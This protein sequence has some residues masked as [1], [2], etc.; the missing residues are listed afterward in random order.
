MSSADVRRGQK[1]T[2]GKRRLEAGAGVGAPASSSWLP[3]NLAGALRLDTDAVS[4]F[5][6]QSRS[7][8]DL[9]TT[10]FSPYGGSARA[11][12]ARHEIARRASRSSKSS[13]S[14]SQAQQSRLDDDHDLSDLPV[15]AN[16]IAAVC[17]ANAADADADAD[18][19][20]KPEV[21]ALTLYRGGAEGE[22]GSDDSDD[23]GDDGASVASSCSSAS[24]LDIPLNSARRLELT[25][26]TGLNA[27]LEACREF[28]T[29][30][31]SALIDKLDREHATL[32]HHLL[33]DAGVQALCRC[34]ARN[35][36]IRALD[37][38]NCNV[39]QRGAQALS[40]LLRCNATL[41]SLSL[42][43]NGM[44]QEAGAK[45]VECLA[46]GGGEKDSGEEK[47]HGH[48]DRDDD[49]QEFCD[50]SDEDE[51]SDEEAMFA[52]AQGLQRLDL[53]N[54]KLGDRWASGF[55]R[56]APSCLT[57]LAL[58]KNNI[59]NAG[60]RALASWLVSAGPLLRELD[61]GWN[62]IKSHGAKALFAALAVPESR[63]IVMDLSWNG[64]ADE[65]ALAQSLGVAVAEAPA[66]ELLN[67]GHNR[68]GRNCASSIATAL[69][70]GASL[71]SLQLGYN[72]GIGLKGALD[73]LASARQAHTLRVLGLQSVDPQA[74]S[75]KAVR[76]AAAEC[77]KARDAFLQVLCSYL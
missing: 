35:H 26:A 53:S 58:S 5:M 4:R 59:G 47:S 36:Y 28:G 57:H 67:L 23:S 70:K 45:L 9:V 65:A 56:G 38:S 22:S 40:D 30:P 51:D 6:V 50:Y 13:E 74:Q 14:Q 63:V 68:L 15:Q 25:A 64:I 27:Y 37:L 7:K 16:A 24:S 2:K 49:K 32:A 11:T 75:M 19:D 10:L 73:V 48:D 44:G 31:V 62:N 34:L 54:N 46:L 55:G 18:A 41:V 60:A 3:A 17:D 1:G 66:L 52:P 33:G 39:K 12:D 69:P 21:F 77:V 43:D 72:A 76:K 71:R 42:A 20:P 8:A 61:L 29:A